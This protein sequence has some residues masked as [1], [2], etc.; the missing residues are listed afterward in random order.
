META[1]L[2]AYDIDLVSFMQAKRIG[3]PFGKIPDKPEWQKIETEEEPT[4]CKSNQDMRTS[5][6]DFLW[7]NRGL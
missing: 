4:V 6:L 3:N 7:M 2:M 5:A 1:A